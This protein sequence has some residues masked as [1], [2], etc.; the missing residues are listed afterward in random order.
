MPQKAGHAPGKY[1]EGLEMAGLLAATNETENV[2][3]GA[4]TMVHCASP[5]SHL[6]GA[7]KRRDLVLRRYRGPHGGR[8]NK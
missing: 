3:P 2:A 8:T 4:C 7:A 5:F 6:D 1:R